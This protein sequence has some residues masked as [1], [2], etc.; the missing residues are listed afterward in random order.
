[1]LPPT[2]PMTSTLGLVPAKAE[3]CARTIEKMASNDV[4]PTL[5]EFFD[6]TPPELMTDPAERNAL[7]KRSDC[8]EVRIRRV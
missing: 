4:A 7:G 3:E 2:G 6:M 8:P 5:K 1:M